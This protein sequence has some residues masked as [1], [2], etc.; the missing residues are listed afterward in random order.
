MG[1]S[2]LTDIKKE[3]ILYSELEAEILVA[4]SWDY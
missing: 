2:N 4:S 1:G 3:M